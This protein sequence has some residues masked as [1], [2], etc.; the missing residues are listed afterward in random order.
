MTRRGYVQLAIERLPFI[1]ATHLPGI[2]AEI[3]GFFIGDLRISKLTWAE[4]SLLEKSRFMDDLQDVFA[5]GREPLFIVASGFPGKDE[6]AQ[7]FV[8][9]TTV[10]AIE[11]LMRAIRLLKSGEVWDPLEFVIYTRF[12]GLNT[13]DPRL[14]GRLAFQVSGGDQFISLSVQDIDCLEGLYSAL[15]L[16]DC[17]RHDLEIDRAET[18]LAASFSPAHTS[19]VH[20]ILPLLGAIEI[21]AGREIHPL[22]KAEWVDD[23]TRSWIEGYAS[24]RNALAHGRRHDP[25]ALK[26]VLETTRRVARVLIREAIAW[27]LL[28]PGT[29]SVTGPQLLTRATVREAAD[30]GRL[31]ALHTSYA[32]MADFRQPSI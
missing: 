8:K 10:V 21:L 4:C 11:R 14:F 24:L 27:R 29:A 19:Y 5:L 20:R 22:A 1:F 15:T 9:L 16:F 23:N 17:F 31:A 12:E 7:R 2:T 6:S 30:P 26:A 13:R 18:L 28:G 3:E 25:E 32:S